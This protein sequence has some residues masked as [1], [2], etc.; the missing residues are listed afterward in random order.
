MIEIESVVTTTEAISMKVE[1][2]KIEELKYDDGNVTAVFY[3]NGLAV[4]NGEL[5]VRKD[6]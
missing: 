4:L 1:Q 3:D 2:Q 5:K 6:D